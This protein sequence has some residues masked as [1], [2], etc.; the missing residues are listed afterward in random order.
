[1]KSQWL[2]VSGKKITSEIWGGSRAGQVGPGQY[3]GQW[4]AQALVAWCAGRPWLAAC[5]LAS[6]HGPTAR[7]ARRGRGGTPHGRLPSAVSRLPSAPLPL[8]ALRYWRPGGMRPGDRDRGTGGGRAG[9]GG[10]RGAAACGRAL[11]AGQ[12]WRGWRRGT[13]SAGRGR[14]VAGRGTNGSVGLQ[15]FALRPEGREMD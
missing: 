2:H 9:S 6:C 5:A 14:A 1:M 13:G 4:E 3:C 8:C 10:R 11:G 15:G 12:A 7:A